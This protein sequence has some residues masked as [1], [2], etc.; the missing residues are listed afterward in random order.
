MEGA[1]GRDGDW[2][3]G[4]VSQKL[5]DGKDISFWEGVWA[6]DKSLKDEFP[7]L[8]HLCANKEGL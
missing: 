7:R 2:F 6:G 1:I 3:W 8:F 4:N 5:G